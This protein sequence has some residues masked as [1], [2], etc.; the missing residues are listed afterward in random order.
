MS[1]IKVIYKLLS[2]LPLLGCLVYYSYILRVMVF[3]GKNAFVG[4][5]TSLGYKQH[6]QLVWWTLNHTIYG[7][8]GWVLIT[9]II[10]FSSFKTS[11]ITK[12]NVKIFLGGASWYL[13]LFIL[14]PFMSWFFD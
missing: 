9:L 3:Q 1:I 2:L 5:P 12:K 13:G 6:N 7:I 10:Y 11:L 8:L 14:D 4:D